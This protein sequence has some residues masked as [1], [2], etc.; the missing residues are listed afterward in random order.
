MK[1]EISVQITVASKILAKLPPDNLP[2]IFIIP[3]VKPKVTKRL[4]IKKTVR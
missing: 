3:K 4:A 2:K 1:N